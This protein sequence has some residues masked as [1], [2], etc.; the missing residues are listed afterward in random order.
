[1]SIKIID[2]RV[3]YLI[4]STYN[5]DSIVVGSTMTRFFRYAMSFGAFPAYNHE[6]IPFWENA[7]EVNDIRIARKDIQEG[8]SGDF[9]SGVPIYR[10]LGLASVNTGVYTISPQ[11]W[12]TEKPHYSVRY[13]RKSDQVD[14][15][16]HLTGC[17]TTSQIISANY[18]QGGQLSG[19]E[20]Y[21]GITLVDPGF[22]GDL[23]SAPTHPT[24]STNELYNVL[25]TF[26]WDIDGTPEDLKPTIGEFSLQITDTGVVLPPEVGSLTATRVLDSRFNYSLALTTMSGKSSTLT[27]YHNEYT[28][29][30]TPVNMTIKHNQ[31][32]TDNYIQ[33]NLTG[34]VPIGKP[35]LQNKVNDQEFDAYRY[36]VKSL[37]ATVKD[38][39]NQSYYGL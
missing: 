4:E 20:T 13:K 24:G 25:D 5:D 23:T 37:T 15:I 31:P 36:M 30:S 12:G 11:A 2:K 9:I 22:G 33:F 14:W 1:M 39:V 29:S 8:I 7:R 17:K 35:D 16:K 32:S 19:V 3:S 10:M 26:S 6:V 27:D 28:N 18:L 38:G 34:L 21:K